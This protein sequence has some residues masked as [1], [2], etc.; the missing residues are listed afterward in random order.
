MFTKP[1]LPLYRVYQISFSWLSRLV[2]KIKKYSVRDSVR[3]LTSFIKSKKKS[4]NV[5]QFF[6]WKSRLSITSGLRKCLSR[7][8]KDIAKSPS[9]SS[10]TKFYEKS[11]TAKPNLPRLYCHFCGET[12]YFFQDQVLMWSYG[13]LLFTE[14]TYT[15]FLRTWISSYRL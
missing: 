7:S 6:F 4:Q 9:F 8:A 12:K 10:F 1:K 2:V 15:Y 14:C 3:F 13:H 11:V 5:F